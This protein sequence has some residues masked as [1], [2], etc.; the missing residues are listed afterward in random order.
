MAARKSKKSK[1]YKVVRITWLDHFHQSADSWL[2]IASVDTKLTSVVTV[3][4][5]IDENAAR[6]VIAHTV[7]PD[8]GN[9]CGTFHIA[10]ALTAKV[11]FL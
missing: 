9:I 10:K 5:L 1:R 4:H 6:Y 8:N 7:D 3:G 2:A 11:E